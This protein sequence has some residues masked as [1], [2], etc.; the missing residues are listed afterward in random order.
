MEVVVALAV[1]Q[2]GEPAVVA[3]A[4]LVA[5]RLPAKGMR[6]RIDQEGQ[7]VTDDQAQHAR[8]Q[9]HA[10]QVAVQPA[11]RERH[12]EI[13]PDC[14]DV[15]VL[16]L[17]RDDRVALQVPDI[18]E[19]R[20]AARIAAQHPADVRE[21]EAAARR[22][23]IAVVVVHELVMVAV[24]RG[25]DQ[26]AVLQRH[27]AEDHADEPER[28]VGVVGPVRPE[29]VIACR[30]GKSVAIQQDSEPGPGGD[31]VAVRESVP[32]H[33]GHRDRER[34]YEHQGRGPD[35]GCTFRGSGRIHPGFSGKAKT[36]HC[37]RS[38][39]ACIPR[40]RSQFTF[41]GQIAIP[42]PPG[43]RLRRG[44]RAETARRPARN[45][46]RNWPVPC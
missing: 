18:A 13:E 22:I 42:A 43:P 15:V 34:Q 40:I 2:D 20:L 6:C 1:G 11:E 30:D 19:V 26:D 27:R 10:P 5:V 28:P 33:D 45:S 35:D 24:A 3:R 31:A 4:V 41:L 37:G 7:V 32:R 36:G 39:A 17:E 25:P 9:E 12:Q 8:E 29:A 44:Y 46:H 23:G 14:E 16:V 21:P 38:G